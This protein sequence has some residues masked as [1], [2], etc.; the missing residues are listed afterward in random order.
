MQIAF[1]KFAWLTAALAYVSG[2][3]YSDLHMRSNTRL[4]IWGAQLSIE[5][6]N[7]KFATDLCDFGAQGKHGVG[8]PPVQESSIHLG[9]LLRKLELLPP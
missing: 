1:P 3:G 4:H 5:K 9:D 7:L 2:A 6:N 8:G